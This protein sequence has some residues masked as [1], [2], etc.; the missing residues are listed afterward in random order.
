MDACYLGDDYYVIPDNLYPGNVQAVVYNE[1]IAEKYNIEIPEEYEDTLQFFEELLINAEKSGF[2]GCPSSRGDGFGIAIPDVNMECFGDSISAAYGVLPDMSSDYIIE[3]IYETDEF[4]NYCLK[5]REWMDKGYLDPD[6]FSEGRPVLDDLINEK[7]FCVL[8]SGAFSSPSRTLSGNKLSYIMKNEPEITGD[9]VKG[10]SLAITS[11]CR[12][13]EKCM[14]FINLLYTDENLSRL[15]NHGIEGVHYIKKSDHIIELPAGVNPGEAGYGSA[16]V[17][18][19][20]SSMNYLY[21]PDTEDD[22]ENMHNFSSEKAGMSIAFGYSFDAQS[23]AARVAAV[24][25]VI[26]KYRP[27]LLC[28]LVDVE[29]VYPEFIDELKKAGIDDI[30]AENQRQLDA[31]LENNGKKS[32]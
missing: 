16:M 27:G 25:Q 14:E 17:S 28:G 22:F 8:S 7:I 2:P 26:N 18:I 11:F 32:E 5:I 31:W 15:I 30:I 12:N 19:G 24:T 3:D 6:S 29:N 10:Q 23:V 1:S 21:V 9:N 4:Y 20:D 13:P